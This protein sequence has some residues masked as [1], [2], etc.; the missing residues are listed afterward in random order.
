MTCPEFYNKTAQQVIKLQ[1]HIE[2]LPDVFQYIYIALSPIE[3][4]RAE[5]KYVQYVG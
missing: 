2:M 3:V 1:S 5:F 4:K